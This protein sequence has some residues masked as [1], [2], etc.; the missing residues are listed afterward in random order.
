MKAKL[1]F[2]EKNVQNDGSILEAVIWVLPEKT[3]D[4]P[5]G[6]K[7]RLYYGDS[8][9]RC[10]VR[11]DNESGKGD[12]KHVGKQELPY[13]FV[14]CPTLLNDF[15]QDVQACRQKRRK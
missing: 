2:K 3:V 14:D 10:M 6:L 15:Y 11:Y 5:H 8:K 12:H 9:G 13:Q 1:F 7:Y 4:R